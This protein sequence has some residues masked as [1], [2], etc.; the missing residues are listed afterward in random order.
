MGRRAR[1]GHALFLPPVLRRMGRA[2]RIVWLDS[3]SGCVKDGLRDFDAATRASVEGEIVKMT[4]AGAIGH[5]ENGGKSDGGKGGNGIGMGW[6]G[7]WTERCS[8]ER[9]GTGKVLR[10]RVR[11]RA[12]RGSCQSKKHGRKGEEKV[13]G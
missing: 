10:V 6:D 13:E 7:S 11:V 1:S 8:K 4:A 12:R 3:S 9:N 5:V 2:G